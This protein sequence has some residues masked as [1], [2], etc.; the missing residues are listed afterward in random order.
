MDCFGFF[1]QN[2]IYGR[3]K[4][5][6]QIYFDYFC[7][8]IQKPFMKNSIKFAVICCLAAIVSVS[9]HKDDNTGKI[10]F[11]PDGI[12]F[13]AAGTTAVAHYTT[14]NVKVGLYI[15][16]LPVGWPDP[17]IDESKRTLTITAPSAADIESGVAV[18]QGDIDMHGTSTSNIL[19]S[20]ILYVAI[21][22][23]V[24]WSA[25]VANS[26]LVNQSNTN[27]LID[28]THKPDGTPL[29][30]DHVAVVWGTSSTIVRYLDFHDGKAS[31]YI[32]VDDDDNASLEAGNAVI[33]A[34]N[35]KNELIW[36]WHIWVADFDADATA[37]HYQ[38]GYTVMDRNLG[39][40]GIADSTAD[41][42]LQT[43]GLFYQWGRK[44]PFI[45][46]DD[47][48]A[49]Q[50]IAGAI[51]DGDGKEIFT[52]IVSSD[53]NTGTQ[54]Y[55]TQHPMTFITGN[56]ANDNDWLFGNSSDALWG[57]TKTVNDPCPYGWQVAASEAFDGLAIANDLTLGYE[58]Y[59]DLYGWMLT[60]GITSS[61]YAAPG[62]IRYDNGKFLNVY[63]PLPATKANSAMEAQPWEGLYWTNAAGKIFYFW[64]NKAD[65]AASGVQNRV[66]YYRAN[67]LPVRCMKSSN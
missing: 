54:E 51:Y 50:G 17:I 31:F 10:T 6:T 45:G 46:P 2:H 3:T 37:L 16:G 44:D 39:A 34:Y 36:S 27:Y 67:G 5:T 9:C 14:S 60:D 33:G 57:A 4:I 65:V 52:D 26:Y 63:N 48:H 42:I 28:A 1:R 23:T 47:Y 49:I 61:L 53:A 66:D 62:R 11:D 8:Q 25:H 21:A 40:T 38:N 15:N 59:Y 35:D 56:T 18:T 32:G 12:I 30:T 20:G 7:E 43:Y 22:P 58:P 41:E 55:A 13:S 24:D 29:A 64:F 19:V